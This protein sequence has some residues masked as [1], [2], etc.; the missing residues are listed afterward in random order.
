MWMWIDLFS[1]DD[2]IDINLK[3]DSEIWVWDDGYIFGISF[4]ETIPKLEIKLT[5][6]IEFLNDQIVN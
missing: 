6:Y 2:L 3:Q 1:R 4:S 5:E